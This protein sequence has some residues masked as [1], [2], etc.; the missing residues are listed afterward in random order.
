MIY[1]EILLWIDAISFIF[2]VWKMIIDKD[3]DF[4]GVMFVMLSNIMLITKVLLN[5]S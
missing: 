1:L 2:S 4:V 3:E 5:K